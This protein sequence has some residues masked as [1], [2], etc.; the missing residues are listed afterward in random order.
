M[1]AHWAGMIG[2]L[3]LPTTTYRPLRMCVKSGEPSLK[4]MERT[5]VGWLT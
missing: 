3:S 2:L 1:S 4:G 5:M